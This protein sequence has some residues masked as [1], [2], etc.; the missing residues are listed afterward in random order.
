ML[1]QSVKPQPSF[2]WELNLTEI[3]LD[4]RDEAVKVIDRYCQEAS[5]DSA[6]ESLR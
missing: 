5:E 2:I 1:A 3:K 6:D 4:G